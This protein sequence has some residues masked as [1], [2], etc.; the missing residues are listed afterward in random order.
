MIT[1][2]PSLPPAMRRAVMGAWTLKRDWWVEYH[3]ILVAERHELKTLEP[4]HRPKPEWV[5]ETCHLEFWR[6]LDVFHMTIPY[7]ARQLLCLD[8]GSLTN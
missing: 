8:K 4:D 3:V 5:V 7:L 6:E 2:A 1:I